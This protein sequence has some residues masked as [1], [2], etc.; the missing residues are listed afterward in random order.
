MKILFSSQDFWYWATTQMFSI[1][2]HLLMN[3]FDWKIWVVENKSTIIFFQNFIK[4]NPDSNV[5]LQKDFDD[6]YDIYIWIY[7]PNIIFYAKK[8]NKKNIFLCNLTF[9]WNE[10]LIEKYNLDNINIDNIDFTKIKN[11]HELIILAYVFADTV[12]IRSSDKLDKKSLLY[13]IVKDKIHYIGPIIYPK[14]V[15]K[16]EPSH[17]LIQLWWQVNPITNEDFYCIYFEIVKK[18]LDKIEWKKILCI[19]PSLE[20]FWKQ[21]FPDTE[22]LP[23]L[24]QFEYQKLLSQSSTIFSPFWINTY[25][26]TTYF[27]TPT[28]L[29]PEQHLWHI[30]SLLNYFPIDTLKKYWTLLYTQQPYNLQWDN[31]SDFI[32]FLLREYTKILKEDS[33]KILNS[34]NLWNIMIDNNYQSLVNKDIE[35]LLDILN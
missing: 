32:Q 18:I 22:I 8:R 29:L 33:L 6:T 7:D 19:N 23:T 13:N 1:I 9:L 16:I 26:E 28:Y 10:K 11:H 34:K 30:K 17:I 12:F 25:F 21:Y 24:S 14:M 35:V 3:W 4:E 2:Q 5:V 20:K 31:E 27:N 15:E